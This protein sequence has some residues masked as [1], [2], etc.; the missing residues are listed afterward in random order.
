MEIG[1]SGIQD[2][3]LTGEVGAGIGTNAV[4]AIN[5]AGQSTSMGGIGVSDKTVIGVATGGRIS[6]ISGRA[7]GDGV[8]AN[9]LK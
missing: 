9:F 1:R 6:L 4:G 8:S 3:Y 2:V 5:E 7:S